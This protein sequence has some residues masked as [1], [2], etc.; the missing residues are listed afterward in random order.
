MRLVIRM[1]RVWIADEMIPLCRDIHVMYVGDPG[2]FTHW[3]WEYHPYLRWS[4]GSETWIGG[5]SNSWDVAVLYGLQA[6]QNADRYARIGFASKRRPL[7]RR[8]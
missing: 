2:T 1:R 4:D 5:S 3:Y 7:G 8:G 6:L